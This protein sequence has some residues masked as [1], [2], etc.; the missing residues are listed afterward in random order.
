MVFRNF[1]I[2]ASS[3]GGG[4]PG[5]SIDMYRME[6]VEKLLGLSRTK[7]VGL[8]LLC[9]CDY[10]QGVSGV[11]K[12]TAVKFLS[13]LKDD[14]VFPRQETLQNCQLTDADLLLVI[15]SLNTILFLQTGF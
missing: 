8:S 10:N 14:E 12:E 9:G 2:S 7:L 4:G 5:F 6:Q 1:T 11:G 15:Y 13:T 3:G